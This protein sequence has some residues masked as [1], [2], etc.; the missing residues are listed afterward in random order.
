MGAE[1]WEGEPQAKRDGQDERPC[2]ETEEVEDHGRCSSSRGTGY[3]CVQL[4][5]C[6]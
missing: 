2:R 5:M 4:R 1:K 6:E 3:L